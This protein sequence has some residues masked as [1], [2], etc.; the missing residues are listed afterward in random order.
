MAPV[1]NV[2]I[3]VMIKERDVDNAVTCYPIQAAFGR[4]SDTIHANDILDDVATIINA[5]SFSD[6]PDVAVSIVTVI[7]DIYAEDLTTQN[8]AAM[9]VDDIVDNIL[10]GSGVLDIVINVQNN[11]DNISWVVLEGE[12]IITEL[13][14]IST[15]TSNE[16][17]VDAE[18]TTTVLVY[19]YLPQIFEA[20]DVF[21]DVNTED[22]NTSNDSTVA[23][24]IQDQLYNIAGQSQQLI[25]NL[26]ATLQATLQAVTVVRDVSIINETEVAQ[27]V[28]NLN[29]LAQSLVDYATLAASKALSKSEEA[30]TNNYETDRKITR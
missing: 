9:M 22:S 13:T 21:V 25:E 23:S 2:S 24:V 11:T 5:T 16:D 8:E 12:D 14:T 4:I 28:E 3:T 19:S 26:E 30:E 6:N 17:I 18:T 27:V 20:I 29:N 1:G 15:I 10:E 7:E